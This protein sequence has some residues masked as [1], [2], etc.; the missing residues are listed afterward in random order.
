MKNKEAIEIRERRPAI[1]RDTVYNLLV[2]ILEH[3]S[4]DDHHHIISKL[5]AY[6]EQFHQTH[7]S[8]CIELAATTFLYISS[9]E[10]N[11]IRI[12]ASI[13]AETC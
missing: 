2:I 1:N 11:Q 12:L 10:F 8:Q 5:F 7:W 13:Y 3:L 6:N 4:C 9:Y